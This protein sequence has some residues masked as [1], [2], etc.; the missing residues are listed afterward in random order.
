MLGCSS[1]PLWRKMR[2]SQGSCVGAVWHVPISRLRSCLLVRWGCHNRFL[3]HPAMRIPL[4]AA[5]S[6][7][8]RAQAAARPPMHTDF[9]SI[10]FAGRG[11]MSIALC[12]LF[13]LSA[14]W[15]ILIGVIRDNAASV[16]LRP[17]PWKCAQSAAHLHRFRCTPHGGG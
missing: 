15:L 17:G 2:R 9:C 10:A 7:L 12:S 11:T 1:S 5:D 14:V 16:A 3:L 13:I 8:S 4:M 6:S